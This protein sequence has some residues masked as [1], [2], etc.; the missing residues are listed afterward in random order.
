[1]PNRI[2]VLSAI[3]T[4]PQNA[5][6]RTRIFRL[7]DDLRSLG[8]QVSFVYLN[9]RCQPNDVNW[10]HLTDY[11]KKNLYTPTFRELANA[12]VLPDGNDTISRHYSPDDW[13]DD[14]AINSLCQIAAE[15]RPDIV[16]VE[17]LMLSRAFEVFGPSVTKV[18]D[19]HDIFSNRDQELA[20]GGIYYRDQIAPTF[21]VEEERSSLNRADTIVAIQANDAQYFRSIS[22]RPVEV[23]GHRAIRSHRTHSLNQPPTLLFVGSRGLINRANAERIIN[24]ILPIVRQAEPNA[25]LRMVGG[26]CDFFPEVIPYVDKVPY[27]EDL[28]ALYSSAT[29]AI[30]A[31]RAATGL[32]IKTVTALGHECPLVS[33]SV[34]CR[35]L[36]EGKGIAYLQADSSEEIGSTIIEILRNPELASR[37][38]L[39]AREFID[40]YNR[41]YY[42]SLDLVF[43]DRD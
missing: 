25:R 8:H 6:H 4:H 11:W 23:I 39:G 42:R 35:G 19:T 13:F 26:V 3:S 10:D 30:N 16:L 7:L 9:G 41:R 37:L 33:T 18:L 12:A 1:M 40:H 32:S 34:G 2:L 43:G 22:D 27:I 20:K 38:S 31:D 24:E 17:Y 36:E 5:G 21:S 28:S 15:T 14:D 29:V